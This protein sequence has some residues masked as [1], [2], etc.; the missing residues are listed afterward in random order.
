MRLGQAH[1]AQ[2]ERR[3]IAV[4]ELVVASPL[5]FYGWRPLKRGPINEMDTS[6]AGI[7]R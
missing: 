3:V 1:P 5:F 4:Q 7:T 6:H 2:D